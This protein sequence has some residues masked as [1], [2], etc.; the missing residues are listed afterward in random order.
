MIIKLTEQQYKWLSGAKDIIEEGVDWSKNDD[1]TINFSINHKTDNNSN[2][3][4]N[5]V[6]TRVF[7]TK[8][9]ILNGKVLTKTGKESR[10]S[11]SLSQNYNSKNAAIEFYQNVIK[12]VQNGRIGDLK[13]TEG[14]DSTTYKAVKKWFKNNYSDNKIIDACKK[15][16]NRIS[17]DASQVFSTYNRVSNEP[18]S[19]NVARYITGTVPS[20][21]VKYISLF[22]MTDFNFSDA[23]KHGTV[24]QNGNTD[25]ILGITDTERETDERGN[26]KTIDVTYDGKVKP[27]IAQ[28]FSL[29]NV[30][31]GHFKQNYG[32]NGQGGYNS[33][34]EF[35]DKSVIYAD[36][37]LKKEGFRPDVLVSAPS[38]SKFNKYY[39]TN[40]SNKLGIPYFDD[41]FSRNIVNVKFD[42]GKDISAM[43][44]KGFSN[45][46]I[47]E[48]AAQVKG[49][50][51]KEIAYFISEPI[52][53]FVNNNI[54]Y[55]NNIPLVKSSRQKMPI[56][57]IISC[58]SNHAYQM[59]LK[60]IQNNDTLT[61][62]LL[63]N[64]FNESSKLKTKRYDYSYLLSQIQQRVGQRMINNVLQ[65][66]LHLTQQYSEQL[67]SKGYKLR[68]D[69]KR[70]K[71]TQL[72][73]QFR[74][75][76]NNVYIVADKYINQNGEL[77][78]R[79]KNSKFVI[80]D[81]DIN[82]G[83]T[84]KLVIDALKEKLPGNTDNNILC[85]VNAYS[86]SGF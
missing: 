52:R 24:R 38:S 82:S 33:V 29:N 81:E 2:K 48:F 68:F 34:T 1:G 50:A 8:D 56:E 42:N 78:N 32:L 57:Y 11:K 86:G 70:F 25:K 47:M 61:K 53:N 83:A 62:H 45:K 59:C 5:S 65:Q 12:Y 74:P 85:L 64:F 31:P 23:I 26:L 35:L 39:C 46:E 3:G 69:T 80:F 15:S 37:A 71:I 21:N 44:E 6:D 28:N 40:L 36:Y 76:L 19:D 49:M 10:I 7:G 16:I 75:F 13:P 84:L 18:N 20:T 51:Y 58:M 67:Q 54:R 60:Y 73:K 4:T 55:F 17:S 79:Y 72:K 63:Q 41:F 22:S 9:D 14:L 43:K 66:V 27:N 77:F 30:K